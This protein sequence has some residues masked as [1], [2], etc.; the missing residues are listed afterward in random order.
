MADGELQPGGGAHRIAEHVGLL[1][2]HRVHERRHVVRQVGIGDGPVDVGGA[3]VALE[4]E[5]I[6]L[7]GL[8]ELRDDRAHGRDVH[9]G[10]VQHDQRIALAGHLVI[11]LH[12]VDLD[13]VARRL[14]LGKA[15]AG[16]QQGCG[17]EGGAE[18]GSLLLYLVRFRQR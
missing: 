3:A 13:A 2:A 1:E 9:V 16:E 5:R 8:G 17:N 4:L 10:A 7:V 14:G 18:H 15:R 12:A 11:H 6:D